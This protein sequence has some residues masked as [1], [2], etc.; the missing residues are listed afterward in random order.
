MYFI[1]RGKID[2]G[3]LFVKENEALFTSYEEAIPSSLR[4]A[5]YDSVVSLYFINGDMSAALRWVNKII[6]RKWHGREDFQ[7]FA[8]LLAMMIH[9]E[10]GNSDVI[11]S[12]YNS[13]YRFITGYLGK[14]GPEEILVS[15]LR[16]VS[17]LTDPS[18]VN[19]AFSKILEEWP[20]D[21]RNA[22]IFEC[23]DVRLWFRS[24]IEKRPLKAL[25]IE[26]TR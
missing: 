15:F 1:E 8:R 17:R 14:D 9:F 18:S 2:E 20:S 6:T 10:K 23:V 7:S 12:K 11:E 22:R 26:Q 21:H 25:H 5:I 13:Y 4:L 3:I 24:K 16:K 19:R